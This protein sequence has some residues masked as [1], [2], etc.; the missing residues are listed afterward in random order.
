MK[1]SHRTTPAVDQNH[2]QAI[3]GLDGQQQAGSGGNHSVAR[4]R[5]GRNRI[6][7]VNDVGV[8]LFESNQ[9]PKRT[10]PMAR[11]AGLHYGPELLQ[12]RCAVALDGR[13]RVVPGESE[14][15]VA[16]PVGGGESS[17]PRGKSVQ[18]PGIQR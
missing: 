4:Q 11:S 16:F 7:A 5:V 18:Q 10:S 12:K 3:G 8:N 6:Q 15:E 13:G 9:R 1:H 14:V 2:G 17:H